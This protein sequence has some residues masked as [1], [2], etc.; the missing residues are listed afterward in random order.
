M[1][2][3]LKNLSLGILLVLTA[4][5]CSS[6][7]QFTAK[8]KQNVQETDSPDDGGGG[9]NE[10]LACP[11][12]AAQNENFSLETAG[13][14]GSNILFWIDDSGSMAGE[15]QKVVWEVRSFIDRVNA[16]TGNNTKIAMVFDIHADAIRNRTFYRDR[17]A[18]G[19]GINPI[20]NP[21]PFYDQIA[22]G[23]VDYIESETWSKHAD[24]AF[25]KAFMP[26]DF[27]Q[28]LPAVV[29]LDTPFDFGDVPLTPA[30]CSGPGM[31]FR[32]R[33]YTSTY[34]YGSPGCISAVN[35]A[36]RLEDQFLPGFNLNIVSI[37]DDDLNI[38]F[39]R[40]NFSGTDPNKN[41][42]PQIVDGM[43]TQLMEPL[44]A[45]YVFNSI[46]GPIGSRAATPSTIEKDGVAHL[47]LTKKTGGASYD[48]RENSW[49]QLFDQLATQVIFSGQ[50]LTTSCQVNAG[51]V[52][53]KFNDNVVDPRD[54]RLDIPR[55]RVN[56]L[57]H[58]FTGFSIG[59]TIQ[60]SIAYKNK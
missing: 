58:A 11:S 26:A 9:N 21:N 8:K 36:R 18:N 44:N 23:E 57:P 31:Y 49:T 22:A 33:E 45:N 30:E 43:I 10:P 37:S 59:D 34:N 50:R 4:T 7:V 53:V 52:V 55:R 47:A 20:L 17:D 60:V 13:I 56:F 14:E 41:A 12:G 46:V 54:Y 48:L 15:F 40:A 19:N 42:Y 32:P 16:A 2:G 38:Q 1:G 3:L 27:M 35:A 39:D 24:I 6:G 5:A 25:A 51:S 28:I 29:P